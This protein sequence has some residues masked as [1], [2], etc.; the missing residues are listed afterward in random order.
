[1]Q[2]KLID[3]LSRHAEGTETERKQ[4][5]R[6]AVHEELAPLAEHV[7]VA[8]VEEQLVARL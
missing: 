7:D 8:Q 3:L 4:Q 1:V 2:E 5:I 6:T